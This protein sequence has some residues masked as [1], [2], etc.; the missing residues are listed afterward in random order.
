MDSPAAADDRG[1]MDEVV[2]GRSTKSDKIRA[3]DGAGY[4]RS[5]IA[6]Y[7][8]IRYQHVWN[9]LAQSTAGKVPEPVTV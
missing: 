2:A 7:L 4:S 3:L 1:P 5:E 9:V 8:G 6:N